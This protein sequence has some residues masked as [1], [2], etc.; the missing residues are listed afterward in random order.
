[1]T[2]HG[3]ISSPDQAPFDIDPSPLRDHKVS[4]FQFS[5]V[6]YQMEGLDECLNNRL[7]NLDSIISSL[8]HPLKGSPIYPTHT[9]NNSIPPAHTTSQTHRP[10]QLYPPIP[11]LFYPIDPHNN[12]AP[13]NPPVYST[14]QHNHSIPSTSTAS[15]NS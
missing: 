13:P 14:H 8:P 7:I 3:F 4:T 10:P 11:Q 12:S 5:H 9:H 1:M 2:E 15:Q 6:W